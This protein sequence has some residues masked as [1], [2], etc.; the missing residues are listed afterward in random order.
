[1]KYQFP[2]DFIWGTATSSFQIEGAW[3]E[4]GKGESIWDRFCHIPGK[5]AE[6]ATGDVACDHYHR[7]KE[8]VALLKE[9]GV[10]SYRFSIS[11]PR[12]FPEGF[13]EP[14]LQGLQF[15]KD[16]IA[17]L[18]N[19]D[20]KPVV[21]LYHWDLP[22]KLQD[23]GGWANLKVVDYFVA[24]AEYLFQELGDSVHTW[25]THNEPWCTAFLGYFYGS[26]APGITDFSTSLK[27][28]HHLLLSHGKVVR[29]FRRMGLMGK[30]GITLNMNP[31]YPKNDTIEAEQASQREDGY[32]NR[33]FT[34]PL[35]LG[36]Y[37][38]DMLT[39]Y[40]R[41]GCVLPE[42]GE[43]DMELIRSPIDFL[44]INYYA[45]GYFEYDDKN[46]PLFNKKVLGDGEITDFNLNICP[47]ALL[48]LLTQLKA[49]YKVKEIVITENGAAFQDQVNEQ[50]LIEDD[51]RVSYLQ[52]HIEQTFQSIEAGIPVTGY[53]VWS[54]LDNFEWASGYQPRFGITYLDYKTQKRTLKKSA[55]W[56]KEVIKQNGLDS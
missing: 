42:I 41:Q 38:E 17:E 48:E 18:Q 7:Y 29:S 13:G 26:F 28:S 24:Y 32:I 45:P 15:Y 40:Q 31:M 47:E 56:Y 5:V 14:N 10:N 44:G 35:Y 36:K 27:V 23:I 39:W 55:L 25:V 37:P 12:I 16:L 3:Q 8:D 33:W 2:K 52:Q 9:I 1:M 22:Q 50:G 43:N 46:W 4:D 19:A 49:T 6:G 53:F 54:L 51:K 21:T 11:W 34:D 20:I 30:I